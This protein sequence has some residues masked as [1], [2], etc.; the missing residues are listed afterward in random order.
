MRVQRIL[1]LASLGR[2]LRSIC[3]PLTHHPLG[4]A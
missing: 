4:A 3:S 2:S 1:N